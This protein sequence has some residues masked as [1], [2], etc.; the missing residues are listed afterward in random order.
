MKYQVCVQQYVEEITSI[1]I[2][3]DT[4]EQAAAIGQQMLN[5]G[6]VDVEAWVA[7]DDITGRDVYAVLDP[8]GETVWER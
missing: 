3:A 1:E 7:G 2:E 4:S 6:N 8:G 5:D